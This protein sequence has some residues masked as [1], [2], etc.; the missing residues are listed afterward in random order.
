MD[1]LLHCMTGQT[2]WLCLF[3]SRHEII[4]L[5]KMEHREI[6]LLYLNGNVSCCDTVKIY[7]LLPLGKVSGY[8][9]TTF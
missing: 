1:M 6:S 5:K 3:A 9:L 4:I 8:I 2:K 7:V